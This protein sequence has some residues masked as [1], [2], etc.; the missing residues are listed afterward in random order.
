M[1]NPFAITLHIDAARVN[2]AAMNH[3]THVNKA[4]LQNAQTY[5]TCARVRLDADDPRQDAIRQNLDAAI[6]ELAYARACASP[7]DVLRHYVNNTARWL[8]GAAAGMKEVSA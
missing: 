3:T 6:K 8:A 1:N 7:D 5:A 2:I 4:L